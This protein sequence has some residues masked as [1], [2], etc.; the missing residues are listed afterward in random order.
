[1]KTKISLSVAALLLTLSANCQ[2]ISVNLSFNAVNNMAATRLDSVKVLNQTQDTDTVIIYPDTTLTI[3][4]TPGDTLLY[5][6]YSNGF[7]VGVQE[8]DREKVQFQVFQNYPNPVKDQ[9][10]ISVFIPEK[11]T[12]RVMVTD[13]SGRPVINS[14]WQLDKGSHSF[15][16]I[17]GDGRLFILTAGWNGINQSVKILTTEP[18]AN[19][20]CTLE[21]A[22]TGKV[23]PPLKVLSQVSAPSMES[24]ITDTPGTNK[25]YTFQFATN[26]PCPGTPTITYEGQV[27]KTIQIFSQCWIKENLNVGTMIPGTQNMVNNGIIEKYCF[28]NLPDSCTK[29]GGLYQWDEMMQYTT[30][31]GVQGICPPDWH[32]PTDEDWKILEGALD[33]YYPIG[34]NVWDSRGLRGFDVGKNLKTT[35]GWMNNGNG[36]DLFG[37]SALPASYR[38]LTGGFDLTGYEGVWWIST[39]SR[40]DYAWYRNLWF[41]SSKAGRFDDSY[42]YKDYGFSVRCLRNY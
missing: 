24:G 9:S 26:I 38:I 4:I 40:S 37:F 23:V 21:Y 19:T 31:P 22:G 29:Y 41:S 10:V 36:T 13:I 16:F 8:A 32:L 3:E 5:I 14:D 30:Q 12:V 20:K 1:M 33:S 17:P 2:K 11:G 15:R 42:S 35:S 25:N 34:D 7:A 6:G 39:E 27:Y 18:K 28:N